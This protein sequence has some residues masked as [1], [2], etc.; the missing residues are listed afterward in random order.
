MVKGIDDESLDIIVF[1]DEGSGCVDFETVCVDQ[2]ISQI[3]FNVELG[4]IYYIIWD[5]YN[6]VVIDKFLFIVGCCSFICD[7]VFCG[8]EDGCG[9][10]CGCVE[11]EVCFDMDM[12]DEVDG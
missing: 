3:V 12:E 8:G 10:I 5:F 9:G 7:G 2:V 1:K 6:G 11:G 4:V